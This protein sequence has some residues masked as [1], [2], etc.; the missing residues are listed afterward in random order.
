M[1]NSSAVTAAVDI[2]P[3][4]EPEEVQVEEVKVDD[5]M[6][7]RETLD[8]YIKVTRNQKCIKSPQPPL[9]NYYINSNKQTPPPTPIGTTL[10]S[11]YPSF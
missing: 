10:A 3:E 11:N 9:L 8:Q 2:T 6:A 5:K 7:E 4:V 1:I